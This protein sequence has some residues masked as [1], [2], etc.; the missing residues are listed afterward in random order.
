MMKNIIEV[1]NGRML[2][3]FFVLFFIACLGL[4]ISKN[5]ITTILS[6]EI[7]FLSASSLFIFAS[8]H[9]DDC[10]GILATFLFLSLIGGEVVASLSLVIL[11]RNFYNNIYNTNLLNL[12][13]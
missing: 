13:S 2:F 1:V 4:S 6:L 11:L 7:M 9:I 8:M 5:L 3:F 10:I 12:K